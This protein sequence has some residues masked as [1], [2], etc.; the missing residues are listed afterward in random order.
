M[1]GEVRPVAIRGRAN[2]GPRWGVREAQPRAA[3]AHPE[4]APGPFPTEQP[5]VYS[6]RSRLLPSGR[7]I[8]LASALLVGAAGAYV[9]ARETSVFAVRTVSVSGAPPAVALQVQHALR[10]DLGTSLLRI[11]LDQARTTLTSLPAVL[12]VSFD[13]AF[14]HTLRV[15]V[16]PER[17]VAV[18]RQGSASWL[19]S[20]RG[21]VMAGLARGARAGLPRIWIGKG[22]SFSVGA[23]VD[24]SLLPALQAVTPLTAMRFPARITSVQTTKGD[25][26][27]VLRSGVE[28]RLGDQHDVPLKLA[29]AAN[30]LPLIDASTRYVDVS[31]PDRPVSGTVLD[32]SRTAPTT[33]GES[34]GQT[35]KS[36]VEVKTP[37]SSGP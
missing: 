23:P 16:V 27:L 2:R 20:A 29:V 13:R 22:V 30:V 4:A 31:V 8:L 14:P 21:R 35:L 5:H 33:T 18:V 11:D 6:A 24:T 17:P 36:Q 32:T 37:V 1:G 9:A 7:S 15:T 34:T 10:D 25:L 28:V 26:T 19:V 3:P 12:S